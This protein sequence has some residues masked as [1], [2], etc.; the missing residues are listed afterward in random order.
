VDFRSGTVKKD[1][2]PS[3][4]F[5][6]IAGLWLKPNSPLAAAVR[7]QGVSATLSPALSARLAALGNEADAGMV[8]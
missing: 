1:A 3:V 4:L 6:F 5:A 8:G 7:A 2:H